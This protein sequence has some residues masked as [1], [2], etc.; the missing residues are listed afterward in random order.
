MK[1]RLPECNLTRNE[2]IMIE[3]SMLVVDGAGTSEVDGEYLFVS[4]KNHAG[5]FERHGEY[6]GHTA[7]FTIYKCSLKNGGFQWFLSITPD[8]VEP[9]TSQ[10]IDFYYAP[11]K[12]PDKLPPLN[13][14][15]L[16]TPH[17]RDPAPRVECVRCDVPLVAAAAGIP[18]NVV[19]GD[20]VNG[21][22]SS[23][24]GEESGVQTAAEDEDEE[25]DTSSMAMATGDDE[26]GV[27]SPSEYY[28]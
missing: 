10:D 2:L 23:D 28:E 9:G 16:T 17:C 3:S 13:W 20:V 25:D 4:L 27:A 5:F 6:G 11:A 1:F 12:H 24:E 7:R 21:D 19:G 26:D 15:C 14:S 18:G 8:N 22:S